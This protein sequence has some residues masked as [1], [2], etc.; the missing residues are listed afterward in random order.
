M[1]SLL[2]SKILQ[3]AICHDVDSILGE[4]SYPLSLR[5]DDCLN[6]LHKVAVWR[7][8]SNYNFL[9]AP[10]ICQFAILTAKTWCNGWKDAEA[11]GKWSR[12]IRYCFVLKWLCMNRPGRLGAVHL[13]PI[14]RKIQ[15]SNLY[16]HFMATYVKDIGFTSAYWVTYECC[17]CHNV[18]F[19]NWTVPSQR[20]SCFQS[21]TKD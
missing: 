17:H 19:E 21:L 9:T 10:M 20:W 7:I 5:S 4:W 2:Y 16:V 8:W 13:F 18:P 12:Y 14:A 1:S 11:L 3:H 15:V 6:R